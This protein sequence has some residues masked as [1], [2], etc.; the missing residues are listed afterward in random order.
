MTQTSSIYDHFII[1]PST[2]TLTFNLQGQMFQIA[3]L[4]LKKN[5]CATLVWNP[6]INVEVMA[7]TSSIYDHFIIWPSSVVLKFHL[8]KQMPQMVLLL[9]KDNNCVKLF[10]NPFINVQVMA[11]TSSIYDHFI[12]WPSSVTL[13]FIQLNKCFK[14]HLYSSKR[15]IVSN[16]FGIYA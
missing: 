14:W 16:Y 10:W 1:W 8:S 15:T 5:N 3:L 11:Q 2:V 13:I 4:F 9:L 12:I 6:C 7:H